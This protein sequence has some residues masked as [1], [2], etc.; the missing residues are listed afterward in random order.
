M[1]RTVEWAKERLAHELDMAHQR[2]ERRVRAIE[3]RDAKSEKTPKPRA[4]L[5]PGRYESALR[6]RLEGKT[7][8][9]IGVVIGRADGSGPITASRSQQ[10]VRRAYRMILHPA[11]RNHPL[12]DAVK[13]WRP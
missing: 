13:G 6:L 3:D 1:K 11:R 9:E 5:F 10:M 2:Y 8:A 12:A 7:Y 4:D